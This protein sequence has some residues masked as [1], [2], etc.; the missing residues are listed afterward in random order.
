M[1]E[2]SS[3][4][5]K[6]SDFRLVWKE[7]FSFEAE[8]WLREMKKQAEESVDEDS[9]FSESSEEEDPYHLDHCACTL[10]YPLALSTLVLTPLRLL[11]PFLFLY[12]YLHVRLILSC[13]YYSGW[14]EDVLG[15]P[16]TTA[17]IL[18]RARGDSTCLFVSS[19]SKL[20]ES[21]VKEMAAENLVPDVP[22]VPFIFFLTYFFTL[23]P[24]PLLPS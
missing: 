23:L 22:S 4:S 11:S 13:G 21:K 12:T 9:Q 17:E 24:S 2:G 14:I 5:S 10:T 20:L 16:V 18:C 1:K 7:D 15:F 6:E 8:S 3:F 19:A